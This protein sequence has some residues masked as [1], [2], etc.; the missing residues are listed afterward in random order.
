MVHLAFE[1][2]CW[3]GNDD[4]DDDDDD[5]VVVEVSDWCW[6][7]WYW[8]ACCSGASRCEKI[9]NKISFGII[10][11]AEDSSTSDRI[12]VIVKTACLIHDGA[13][14]WRSGR[15]TKLILV[16]HWLAPITCT[17]WPAE[18][19]M[20]PRCSSNATPTGFSPPQSKDEMWWPS[21]VN[22]CSR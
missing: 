9:S 4:D 8:G 17:R 19:A 21:W 3:D 16:S 11:I 18:K 1:A 13:C 10:D 2:L 12:I 5:D 7:W 20:R 15:H 22:A 14:R 6:C